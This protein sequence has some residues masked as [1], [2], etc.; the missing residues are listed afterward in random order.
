[1]WFR[2]GVAEALGTMKIDLKELRG[3][4]LGVQRRKLRWRGC[5][6]GSQGP[7]PNGL[8]GRGLVVCPH[9]PDKSG[10]RPGMG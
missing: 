9:L 2:E 3:G 5:E 6:V 7:E 8:E 4:G 10:C 1:M